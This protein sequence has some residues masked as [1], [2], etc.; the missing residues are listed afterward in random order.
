[1]SDGLKLVRSRWQWRDIG[2]KPVRQ[3]WDPAANEGDGGWAENEKAGGADN[4]FNSRLPEPLRVGSLGDAFEEHGQLLKLILGPVAKRLKELQETPGSTLHTAIAEVSRVANEPVVQYQ[5]DIDR[6]G[7][8]V[9]DGFKGVFPEFD[10]KIKVAMETISIDAHK[11]LAA[12]SSIR[13]IETA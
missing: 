6:I 5:A 11:S 8:Q 10:I 13:F 9:R 3:T 12:G 7:V 2:S 1:M 4:V